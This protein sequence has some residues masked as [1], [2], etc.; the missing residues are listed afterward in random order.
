METAY[1]EIT[2]AATGNEMKSHDNDDVFLQLSG[3]SGNGY[4]NGEIHLLIRSNNGAFC[5][6]WFPYD[7]L[8]AE[9][10]GFDP[11]GD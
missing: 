5:Q 2:I 11:D 3:G 10:K 7:V 6:G 1:N 8:L 9:L 4:E